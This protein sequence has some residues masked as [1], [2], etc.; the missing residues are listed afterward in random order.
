[1]GLDQAREVAAALTQINNAS[2]DTLEGPRAFS[3][4]RAP[5][6]GESR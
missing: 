5:R 6:F 1:M 2:P 3:E 4:K